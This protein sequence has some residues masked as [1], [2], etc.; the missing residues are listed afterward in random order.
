MRQFI[1]H[2]LSIPIE[3]SCANSRSLLDAHSLGVGGLA[4]RS[5]QQLA[6]GSIVHIKIPLL[7]PEFETDARVVWCRDDSLKGAELGV[8]FLNQD[9]AYRARM[10]EQLCHIENYKHEILEKE[11]RQLTQQQAAMEWI[12]KFAAHFPNPDLNPQDEAQHLSSPQHYSR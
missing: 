1:R 10:V 11:G 6:P 12:S 5:Y 2:P 4:F 7:Q 9:D 8:E 3:I